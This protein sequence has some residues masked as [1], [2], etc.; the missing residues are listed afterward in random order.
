MAPCGAP[1]VDAR[2]EYRSDLGSLQLVAAAQPGAPGLCLAAA[3]GVYLAQCESR[4]GMQWLLR[5]ILAPPSPL[6]ATFYMYRA[7][8]DEEYPN[9]NINTAD[10]PGVLWYLQNEVLGPCP[11]KYNITRIRRLRVTLRKDQ[12]V[13]FVAFDR[14]RCTVPGCLSKLSVQGFRVGCQYTNYGGDAARWYSLP[15][16][17]P[18]L[19]A[20]S[21]NLQCL[22]AQPG[23][24]CNGPI[25][26]AGCSYHVED[27]GDVGLSELS[28]IRDFKAFCA[29]GNVEY[30][31]ATQRGRGLDFW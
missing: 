30:D 4:P 22:R 16:A 2:W 8:S 14:A 5:R 3:A 21:K 25:G 9:E 6:I 11:R 23:G 15:G 1:G 18:D 7:Q 13:D 28:G 20:E 12:I 19:P 27:A 10:L 26:T 31:K 17:C 24:A 29:D